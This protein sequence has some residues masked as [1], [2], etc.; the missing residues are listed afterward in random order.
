MDKRVQAKLVEVETTV[1]DADKEGKDSDFVLRYMTSSVHYLKAYAIRFLRQIGNQKLNFLID[2]TGSTHC[3]LSSKLAKTLNLKLDGSIKRPVELANGKKHYTR[4]YIE[5]L[6][7]S[8]NGQ[9]HAGKFF[10]IDMGER[11]VIIGMAWLINNH[12]L[13]Y[14]DGSNHTIHGE[15]RDCKSLLVFTMKF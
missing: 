13:I 3:F 7:L 6:S 2:H 11:D 15:Q 10:V 4:G 9:K 12:V 5:N 14:I 1:E 8:L